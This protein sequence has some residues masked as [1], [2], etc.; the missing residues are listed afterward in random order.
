MATPATTNQI[1]S[2]SILDN[3]NRQVYLGNQYI[4]STNNVTITGTTEQPYILFS[5]PSTNTKGL[6]LNV[7]KLTALSANNAYFRF[8]TNPTVTT[9]G[10]ALAASNLRSASTFTSVASVYT[11]PTV[12]ANGTYLAL[13]ASANYVPDISNVLTITDPGQSLLMTVQVSATSAVAIEF[14][15]YEI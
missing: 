5:N 13:L 9:N 7:K 1:P 12:S 8:Y 14:S 10:T 15:W 6:F 4:A 3:F 11:I 2:D